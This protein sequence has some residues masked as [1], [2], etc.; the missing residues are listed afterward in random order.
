MGVAQGH[1]GRGPQV[2]LLEDLE[3][4]LKELTVGISVLHLDDITLRT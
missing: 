3:A 1:H 4:N 2:E